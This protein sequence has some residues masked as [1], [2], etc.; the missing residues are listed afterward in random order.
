[1]KGTAQTVGRSNRGFVEGKQ[2]GS[3]FCPD[4]ISF[5]NAENMKIIEK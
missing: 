3:F 2:N 4:K 1:M 5:E